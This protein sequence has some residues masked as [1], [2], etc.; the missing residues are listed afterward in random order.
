MSLEIVFGPMFSGKS[1]YALSYVRRIQSIG[2]RVLIIKP[3]NDKRYS[4]EAV[5]IT[6]DKASI[7]CMMWDIK[8]PLECNEDVDCYLIEEAQFFHSL[9]K[10]VK[11]QLFNKKDILIVGLDGCSDQIT[12]GEIVDCIPW[13]TKVT[14]LCALCS[15]CKD[16]TLAPYTKRISKR[17]D[18]ILVGSSE[19][20]SAVCLKHLITE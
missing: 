14:K 7:P 15:K 5:L 2:K 11:M 6:H 12:F 18:K 13:A 17:E 9:L 3:D 10:F 19:I 1:S 8:N 16:G 4:S 20:Y